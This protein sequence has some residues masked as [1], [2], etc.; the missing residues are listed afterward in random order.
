MME[1][2]FSAPV[3]IVFWAVLNALMVGLLIGFVASGFGGSM[4][5][6]EIY[7]S[8]AGLVFL[9]ALLVWLARRRR[10]LALSRGLVVPPRPATMLMLAVAF[11]LLWLGL[12][13]GEW[14]PMIAA[15]PLVTAGLMEL[16]ARRGIRKLPGVVPVGLL[17]RF[18]LMPVC[19][20]P[21]CLLPVQQRE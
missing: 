21:V 11:A 19:L 2:L 9:V 18:R 13:F 14:V 5:V 20:L 7:G 1:R 3:V 8:S 16:Y 6:V 10:R 12:P 15:L 17:V 4:V